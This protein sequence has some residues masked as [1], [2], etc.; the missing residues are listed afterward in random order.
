MFVDACV[1]ASTGVSVE[2]GITGRTVRVCVAD[3]GT[4]YL[5]VG[6]SRAGVFVGVDVGM[7]GVSV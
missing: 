5:G 6:I 3:G 1:E 2:V 7:E 4:S